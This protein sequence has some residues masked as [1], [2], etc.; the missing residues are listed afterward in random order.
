MIFRN[1][2]SAVCLLALFALAACT[3]TRRQAAAPALGQ[4]TDVLVD[5]NPPGDRCA[6][7]TREG[8]LWPRKRDGNMYAVG[9][10]IGEYEANARL[11]ASDNAARDAAFRIFRLVDERRYF[12]E[13]QRN[14]QFYVPVLAQ[15]RETV[16]GSIA[17]TVLR[18][19]NAL[20][21]CIERRQRLVS[22]AIQEYFNVYRLFEVPKEQLPSAIDG[23]KEEL[24][25]AQKQYESAREAEK[26]ELMKRGLQMLDDAKGELFH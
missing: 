20:D 4:P 9:V 26:A 17:K 7:C 24:K 2:S 19:S 3:G 6:D 5:R 18:N 14:S 13:I 10:A 25:K 11:D 21:A 1:K 8:D 22:G 23:A 16:G 15:I 12:S